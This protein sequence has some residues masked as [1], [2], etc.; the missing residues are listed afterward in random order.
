MA[1][2]MQMTLL[3]QKLLYMYFDSNFIEI[4]SERSNQLYCS[5]GSDN[6]SVPYRQRVITWNNGGLVY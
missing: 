5:T 1:A 6:G 2:I 3:K 4:C